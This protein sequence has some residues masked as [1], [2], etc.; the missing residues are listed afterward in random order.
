MEYRK[1]VSVTGLPGLFEIISSKTDG[2]IV[3]SL[4]DKATRFVSSRTH[5]LSH[6][7]S[8]EVYTVNDNVNLAEIFLAMNKAGE[9]LPAEKDANAVKQFFQK[10]FPDL[11]FERVYNSDMK[12]M[13]RWYGIIKAHDIEIKLSEPEEPE[14][15]EDDLEV[16]EVTAAKEADKPAKKAKTII[17][18]ATEEK[19]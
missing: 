11:D 1:I 12:K 6:L 8:I 18:P 14:A 7:E 17:A 2:A 3:R 4:D 15:E 19:S 9:K 5:N 13:V 10:V 16:A